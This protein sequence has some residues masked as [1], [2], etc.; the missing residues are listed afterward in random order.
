MFSEVRCPT[1]VLLEPESVDPALAPMIVLRE[2]VYLTPLPADSPT[3]VL[4]VP[5]TSIPL[6]APTDVFLIPLAFICDF[7]PTDVL[8]APRFDSFP[9]M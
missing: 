7:H 6:E 8:Y 4:S 3:K 1:T 9:A 2:F 5:P